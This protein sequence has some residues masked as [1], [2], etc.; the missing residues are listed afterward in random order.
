MD[1]CIYIRDDILLEV[2]IDDINI[3]DPTKDKCNA[4]FLELSKHLKIQDKDPVKSFLGLNIIRNWHKHLIAINQDGYI[5]RLVAEFGLTN[6]KTA[7]TPL[8]PSL[9]LVPAIPGDKICNILYYQKLTGSLNHLAVY[10][11]PD[12][13]FAVSK[14]AQF[15]SNPT[16]THLKAAL[17]VLR[18]LKGTR[19]LCIVYRKQDHSIA[20]IGYSD[21]DWGSDPSDR[22]SYIGYIFIVNDSPVTWTSHK[23]TTVALSSM[24]AEYM[25][26][27]DAA[28]EAIARLQ[29][30]QELEISSAPILILSDSETVIDLADGTA[31]NHRK[32]KHIDIRYHAVRHYL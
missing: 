15:N 19:N 3:V 23:Q 25:A 28:R 6:A 18:Y 17:R 30:F 13:A 27:S 1:S 21:A 11:R 20:I 8:H 7:D 9:P 22:K 32:A 4:I 10:T 2:Y 12:I 5:D 29:F 31:I 26:L 14:L 16:F 24:E